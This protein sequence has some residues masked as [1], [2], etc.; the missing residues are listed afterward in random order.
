M[1][2]ALRQKGALFIEYALALAFVVVVGT[3]FVSS[4]GLSGNV[5]AICTSASKLLGLAVSQEEGYDPKMMPGSEK[6]KNAV[7][8]FMNGVLAHIN[9]N[10][11]KDGEKFCGDVKS[12]YVKVQDGKYVI[13][14]NVMPTDGTN[15]GCMVYETLPFDLQGA[16]EGSGFVIDRGNIHFDD[17]GN[18]IGETGGNWSQRTEIILKNDENKVI[19]FQAGE[20]GGF[21]A[22]K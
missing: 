9:K 1:I 17:N 6:Y 16:M 18:V 11:G 22:H 21:F 10:Y 15:G 5:K 3:V 14:C 8:Y 13:Q 2:K 19:N 12:V 7:A 4:D 20:N